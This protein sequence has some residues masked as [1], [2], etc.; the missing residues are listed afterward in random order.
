MVWLLFLSF[1]S[2]GAP[3]GPINVIRHP[4]IHACRPLI[5]PAEVQVWV[6]ETAGTLFEHGVKNI[7]PRWGVYN[8][9]LPFGFNFERFAS[10]GVLATRA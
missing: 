1:L 4:P 7:A 2:F 3:W 5:N 6:V 8:L 9:V 10:M